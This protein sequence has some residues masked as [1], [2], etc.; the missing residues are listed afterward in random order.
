MVRTVNPD[1]RDAV[2]ASDALSA[3]YKR[4][5]KEPSDIYRHL[6]TFVRVVTELD[7][8]KV[9]ELGTRSGVSTIA[10]LHGLAKTGGHLWSVDIDPAPAIERRGMG[11]AGWTFVRGDD[12]S[13]TV[14]RALPDAAD[15]VFIDTSH[16][17]SHTMAELSLYQWKVRPG[18]LLML[19]DTELAHPEGTTGLPYPVKRAVLE[20]CGQQHYEWRNDPHCFGL[21]TIKVP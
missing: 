12:C 21:A 13:E 3:E 20:F 7:A 9:I 15:V 14:F 18:G 5:C 4:L 10:W 2:V 16:D 8:Q 6:P 17:Y 19:H 11:L 1:A